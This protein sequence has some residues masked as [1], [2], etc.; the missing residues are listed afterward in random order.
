MADIVVKAYNRAAPAK[1]LGTLSTDKARTWLQQLSETG[2]GE[3]AA[4]IDSADAALLTYDTILRFFLLG[5]DRFAILVE[6]KKRRSIAQGEESEEVV[7]ASGR[8]V[9]ALLDF[10]V[11]FPELG[12]NVRSPEH[13][14]F[15][16]PSVDYDDAAWIAA[17]EIKQQSDTAFGQW[18]TTDEGGAVHQAPV[19]FPDPDAWWI[20]SRPQDLMLSPPQPVGDI[21][22]RDAFTLAAQT[23]VAIVWSADDGG[24][25]FLDD[26]LID[27]EVRAHIWAGFR[28]VD[29]LLDAG[30]HLLAF[31]ATNIERDSV[32]TN[33]AGIIYSVVTTT[34]GGDAY[35][36]VITR[37][38]SS[39]KVLDYPTEAPT[40]TPGQILRVLID[41]AQAR[42][43]L[44]GVT[45]DFDDAVDSDG[46]PWTGVDVVY[47]VG[48]TSYLQIARQLAET[49]IDI[50]MTPALVLRAWVKGDQGSVTAITLVEATH[51][52]SVDHEGEGPL[53]NATLMRTAEGRWVEHT[54]PASV[55][56][57]G[58][59]GSGLS[60]GT[61][62]SDDQAIRTA[63]AVFDEHA[64]PVD[65]VV[66]EVTAIAGSAPYANWGVGDTVNLVASDDSSVASRI[67]TLAVGEDEEGNATYKATARQIP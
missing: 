22:G 20:W 44:V 47:A 32:A 10:S 56:A 28:R 16:F 18:E 65:D 63:E 48:T 62:A 67:H 11:L 57:H 14:Y 45:I 3:T 7:V 64:E 33:V 38:D 41:E 52:H 66:I 26:E 15:S 59:R 60:L 53:S 2:Q 35:G 29:L 46:T 40:M 39:T 61:A 5:M 34:E 6:A 12:L 55:S 4:Q 23:P 51:Y 9:L 50:A 19:D 21:Y 54:R 1:L 8:G 25:L 49:S 58:R 31:K 37:S 24:R 13:R 30:D 36:A 43:E 27:E 42:G 17:T